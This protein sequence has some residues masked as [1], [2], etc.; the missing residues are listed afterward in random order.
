MKPRGLLLTLVALVVLLGGGAIWYFGAGD[1]PASSPQTAPSGQR[2][3]AV[4]PKV[5]GVMLINDTRDARLGPATPMFAECVLTNPTTREIAITSS[6]LTPEVRTA[7][8]APVAVTWEHVG[9]LPTVIA[10][11]ASVGI[12][13][14]ATSRM[15]AGSFEVVAAGASGAAAP[16]EAR[17][18]VDPARVTVAEVADAGEDEAAAIR[19]LAWRG[20]SAD[21]LAR[22]EAV[23]AATPDAL[24]M[25]LWRADLLEDL[26]RGGDAAAQL[27][28]LAAAIDARQRAQPGVRPE[29]P[30][31]LANRLAP[32]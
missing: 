10:A 24:V 31:W 4:A 30:Y 19:L 27:R 29:L 21:A 5:P 8:G 14:V 17:V 6:A 20:Q 1:R 18:L 3:I 22:I 2:R 7:S 9:D 26:G 11:G 23:L 16:G 32:R 13:W 28:Q 15:T 12:R 25:Q